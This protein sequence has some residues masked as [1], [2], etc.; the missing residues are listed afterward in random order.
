MIRRFASQLAVASARTSTGSAGVSISGSQNPWFYGSARSA[1][2]SSIA[3]PATKAGNGLSEASGVSAQ[4]ESPL[5]ETL[6]TFVEPAA[7]YK[8]LVENKIDFF[9][10]VPDSLLKDFCAYVQDNAPAGRHFITSNEGS[11]VAMASGYHLATRKHALVYMQNSGFGNTVN[12]LL[13]LAD[14]KVYSIP[15]LLLI[16]WR[17]EPGHKDEPQHMVQ[18]KVM[19]AL[20]A[21]MNLPFQVLPDYPE[22]AEDAVGAAVHHMRTRGGPYA[23]LVRKQT[24][25][26]YKLKSRAPNVWTLSREQ[27]IQA[28]TQELGKFD[29]VV[30]TTGFTS[31]ELYEYRAASQQGHHRDFLTVGSMG[32]APSI[33]LGIAVAKPSR[34]VVC[35]DGDGGL[36]MHMGTLATVGQVAPSNFKHVLLNNGAHD[37]VGGQPSAGFSVNWPQ[38]AAACGYRHVFS[39]STREELVKVAR[40]MRELEGPVF[41]EVKVN[42]GARSNLGRPKTTPLQN[43]EDLMRFLDE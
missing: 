19:S 10:G 34:S 9:T 7:F 30:S 33:A 12:P 31:R 14:P 43:K 24:F 5:T 40:E 22:G 39:V 15:M 35:L 37:S 25:S 4:Q 38:A 23:L 42:K 2:F 20:L 11:A 41:V 13:S 26:P 36:L 21:D 18:G 8:S 28:I 29:T 6:N 3:T 32:H 16:G 27:A 17:G 1:F